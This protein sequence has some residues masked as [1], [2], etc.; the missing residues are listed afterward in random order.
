MSNITPLLTGTSGIPDSA[1]PSLCS[2]PCRSISL[3]NLAPAQR[4]AWIKCVRRGN[5]HCRWLAVL[6][7]RRRERK[8]R[9][10]RIQ[11]ESSKLK[12]KQFS[13]SLQELWSRPAGLLCLRAGCI[14]QTKEHSLQNF[15]GGNGG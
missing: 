6:A 1:R 3:N 7:L 12:H 9:P 10:H 11:P 4:N 14:Q 2:P 13:S 8:S 5:A 15:S